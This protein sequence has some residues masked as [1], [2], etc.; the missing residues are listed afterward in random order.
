VIFIPLIIIR[1]SV[2]IVLEEPF[3]GCWSNYQDNARPHMAKVA[4]DAL[5]EIGGAPLEHT[6]Y[7]PDL[8]PCNFWAF[9]VINR[10][11]QG[12]KPPGPLSS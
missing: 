4:M 1:V 12:K 6:P 8:T 7:S 9:P 11:L 10:E 5:T 3:L 2:T